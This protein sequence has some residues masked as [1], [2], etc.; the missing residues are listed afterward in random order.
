MGKSIITEDLEHCLL[1]GSTNN[2]EMHHVFFGTADR[3]I[4]DKYGLVVPLCAFHHR[5]NFGVHGDRTLDLMLKEMCQTIFET[6]VGSRED[7]MKLFGR[8]Y[9]D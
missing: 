6:K 4:S 7:F 9:L 8:N 5:G 2:I 3:K 1:C